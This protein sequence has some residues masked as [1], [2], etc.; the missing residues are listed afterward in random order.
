LD[1]KVKSAAKKDEFSTKN[2]AQQ[3]FDEAK[4]EWLSEKAEQFELYVPLEIGNDPVEFERWLKGETQ[5]K[6]LEFESDI[7]YH[8]IQWKGFKKYV[9]R[10]SGKWA[11]SG[12]N[13]REAVRRANEQFADLLRNRLRETIQ[14]WFPRT[15]MHQFL[16]VVTGDPLFIHHN[17]ILDVLLNSKD[18][19]N[20]LLY[21][22]YKVDDLEVNNLDGF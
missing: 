12:I 9:K 20:I 5:R 11:S 21:L 8:Q 1:H 19:I 4:L 15:E 14:E 6:G 7:P 13:N 10:T 22:M 3:A 18:K 16:D 17:F 2:L